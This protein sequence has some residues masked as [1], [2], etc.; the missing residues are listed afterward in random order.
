[1][2]REKEMAQATLNSIGDAVLSTDVNGNVTYLN[3]VAEKLTGW[4]LAEAVGKRISEVFVLVDGNTREICPNPLLVAIGENRIVK[5]AAE[6][7]LI[8]RDGTESAIGDSAAPIHGRNGSVTGGVIVFRDISTRRA[9]GIEMSHFAQHDMLTNLPNR[10]L[11]EDRL[12]VAIEACTRKGTRTAVLYLDLDGFKRTNDSLGHPIGDKLLR[13]VAKRLLA[14]L[15]TCDTVSRQG[16]DEF[17]I[18]LTDIAHARDAGSKAGKILTALSAPHTIDQH[19]LSIT[20]SIG[21]TT[22][23]EDGRDGASLVKNADLAMYQAKAKGGNMYQFFEKG[24]N[25]RATE[26]QQIESDL[27]LALERNEFVVHYQPKLDLKTGE[28]RGVE[29]LMRWQHP[30]RGLLGPLKFLSVAE[31]C[32]LIASLGHWVLHQASKQART[33]QDAGMK[34][35][36]L[37]VN[38]SSVELRNPS[39]LDG[40]RSILQETRMEPRFLEIEI[41]ENVLMQHGEFTASLLRELRKMGVRLAIDDFGTG[42]SSL[43][44]L[45]QFSIDTMK[46]DQSFVHEID[47]QTDD[48][49][50]ISAIIDIGQ[51]LKHRVIAKGVETREQVAFLRSHGCNEAQGYYFSQP[52]LAEAFETFVESSKA[53]SA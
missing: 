28:I 16:G 30:K 35:M 3:G 10:T 39:F 48:A 31:D 17:V 26:R 50:I 23:P 36:E 12:R 1:L 4:T 42:Y 9:I 41:A 22:Y 46:V 5:L 21:I 8:R 40:V 29:A 11:L 49:N 33:W 18:L 14:C 25:L 38:V 44:Y 32:G 43:S 34:P 27:K 53:A 6:C 7:V 51:R 45:R 15:R 20:A 47:A 37:A 2:L 13:S 19:T 24:M 52:L